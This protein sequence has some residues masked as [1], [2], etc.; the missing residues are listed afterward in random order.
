MS[1]S[2][3]R[4]ARGESLRTA[5]VRRFQRE[6]DEAVYRRPTVEGLARCLGISTSSLTRN[7]RSELGRSA[8]DLIDRRLALEVQRLLVHTPE[9]SVSIG[10]RLGFSEPTNFVKFFRRVVGVTPE[11]FRK[12]HRLY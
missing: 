4:Q 10:E 9:T 1:R 6:L 3:S 5:L 8:K 7:C 2:A 11:A 12:A